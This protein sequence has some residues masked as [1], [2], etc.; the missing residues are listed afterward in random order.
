M[1]EYFAFFIL[2]LCTSACLDV[3]AF[4][5]RPDSFVVEEGEMNL[6]VSLGD[7]KLQ[8][9][10][11]MDMALMDMALVDEEVLE[12]DLED[13]APD[14]SECELYEISC[15]GMDDDC[16]GEI[17]EGLR[18][19]CGELGDT[20]VLGLCL[21]AISYCDEGTWSDCSLEAL[22]T[23]IDPL[24]TLIGDEVCDCYDND[25][26][27]LVDEGL[28]GCVPDLSRFT[29]PDP[30]APAHCRFSTTDQTTPLFVSFTGTVYLGSLTVEEGAHVWVTLPFQAQGPGYSV[31]LNQNCVQSNAS[32]VGASLT[33]IANHIM[34]EQGAHLSVSSHLEICDT[35][36][37]QA[38]YPSYPGASGGDLRLFAGELEVAGLLSADG[39]IPARSDAGYDKHNG[40]SGGA[41]GSIQLVSPRL[42]LPSARLSAQGGRGACYDTFA[43]GTGG[44]MCDNS[45]YAGHGPGGEGG[46]PN[47]E[48]RGGGGSGGVTY[49]ETN[50]SR[51][52][53]VLGKL[54][55]LTSVSVEPQSG[56]IDTASNRGTCD[57]YTHFSGGTLSLI[58]AIQCHGEHPQTFTYD[59]LTFIPLD[60]RG[61]PILSDEIGFEIHKADSMRGDAPVFA[62]SSI[63]EAGAFTLK[64]IRRESE[65]AVNS[66][67]A[68]VR[69]LLRA[70]G[71]QSSRVRNVLF[72]AEIISSEPQSS[73]ID[74][75]SMNMG[76]FTVPGPN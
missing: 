56:V 22:S 64:A 49:T 59:Q 29:T 33:V 9:M 39:S 53:R 2:L 10:A 5:M 75:S 44:R 31:G 3:P 66:L 63:G 67:V 43:A 48:N 30:I 17:D 52:L 6:D 27:G 70:T 32:N 69:Y 46:A 12:M 51:D 20:S 57:G 60:A 25:C 26:D 41:A 8:D 76:L 74:L 34:I 50:P 36:Q 54:F 19:R 13:M 23:R 62:L 61:L 35:G 37:G 11:L 68:G 18:A 24:G 28:T 47:G 16:D 15:D 38:Y 73:L 65:T 42:K 71:G 40:Y 4:E 55:G 58:E 45:L 1:K 72:I 7:M 21:E 14:M